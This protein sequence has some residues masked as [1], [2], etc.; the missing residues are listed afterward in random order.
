MRSLAKAVAFAV[1]LAAPAASFAQSNQ[2]VTRA[3]LRAELAQ[4]ERA[5][6]NPNDMLNYPENL[7]A[8]KAKIAAQNPK[9]QGDAS[10]YGGRPDAPSHA[11]EM[12]DIS[13]S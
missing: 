11:G 3:Q 13:G 7:E 2:P 10:A 6:Y 8:A 12:T 1:V 5:G 9:A 4:L